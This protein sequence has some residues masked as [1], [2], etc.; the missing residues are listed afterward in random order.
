MFLFGLSWL[1]DYSWHFKTQWDWEI[2]WM[3]RLRLIET[4]KFVGWRDRD[5]SRLRNLLDVETKTHQDWKI[6]WMLRPRLI[7]TEKFVGCRDR[8]SSRLGNLADVETKTHQDREIYWMSRP[9]P[10][11]TE[12]KMLIPRLHQDSRW[13]LRCHYFQILSRPPRPRKWKNSDAWANKAWRA[14]V[15]G[16]G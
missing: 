14:L 16:E 5:S 7:E 8:D 15:Q 13:S 4:E 9:R 11:E 10:V 12:Q 6:S 2:C 3:S 1:N